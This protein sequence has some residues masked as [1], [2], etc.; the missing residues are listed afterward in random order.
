MT[1]KYLYRSKGVKELAQQLPDYCEVCGKG[2][3][4]LERHHRWRKV[5][6]DNQQYLYN[7]Y[8]HNIAT[9]RGCHNDLPPGSARS[10]ELFKKLRGCEE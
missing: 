1:K 6:Y 9:C 2:T 5:M 7:D 8:S 4:N 10:E 3:L